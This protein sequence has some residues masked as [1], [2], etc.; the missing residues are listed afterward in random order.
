MTKEAKMEM[1]DLLNNISNYIRP[2]GEALRVNSDYICEI[3]MK[4]MSK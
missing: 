3:C 1:K 4:T 2:N